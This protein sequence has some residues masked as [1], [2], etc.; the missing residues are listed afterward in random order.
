MPRHNR[1]NRLRTT[2]QSYLRRQ[3]PEL[4][5]A[6]LQLRVLDGPPG[7]PRYVASAEICD[8]SGCPH[9]GS[10]QAAASSHCGVFDCP[11]RCSMRLLLDGRGSI[12]QA[13]RSG[14]H[15]G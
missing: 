14:I 13:T 6:P 7:A 3:A 9:A 5:D 15:W 4:Q 1:K 10:R 12:M 8:P 11:L 2:V